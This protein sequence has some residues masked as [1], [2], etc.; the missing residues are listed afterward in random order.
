MTLYFCCKSLS[1]DKRAVI[2]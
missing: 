2:F 1:S